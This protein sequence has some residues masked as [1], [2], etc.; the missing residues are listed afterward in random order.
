MMSVT[1]LNYFYVSTDLYDKK[2]NHEIHKQEESS[3]IVFV[4]GEKYK[5]HRADQAQQKE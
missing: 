5:A 4:C 3:N 1:E 2:I